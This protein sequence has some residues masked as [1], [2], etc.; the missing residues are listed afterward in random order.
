MAEEH[1][2]I[3]VPSRLEYLGTLA[4]LVEGLQ[5]PLGLTDD[6]TFALSTALIEAGTN[7]VQHGRNDS[8]K[9][10]RVRLSCNAATIRME[11]EDD[12]TGFDLSRVDLN[13]TDADHIYNSRGRGIFI[14]RS[15]MDEVNFRFGSGSGTTCS[16]LLRR[17][18]APA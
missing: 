18:A 16:L 4:R 12:G 5:D 17:K 8:G 6:E 9:P 15:I 14:M 11:V 13:V 2:Q 1:I 10:I 3:E 7:A